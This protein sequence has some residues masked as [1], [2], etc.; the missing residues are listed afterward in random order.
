MIE[1]E[2]V[3]IN[4][5]ITTL[6]K[7]GDLIVKFHCSFNLSRS[8]NLRTLAE[9]ASFQKTSVTMEIEPDQLSLE[10]GEG[11][12]PAAAAGGGK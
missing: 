4:K 7:V 10:F 6:D 9:L 11:A 3:T 5:V 1:L 8:G 2:N 12:D